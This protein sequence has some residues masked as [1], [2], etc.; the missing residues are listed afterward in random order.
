MKIGIKGDLGV[1]E[2]M[3]LLVLILR[4]RSVHKCA[5]STAEGSYSQFMVAGSE[6]LQRKSP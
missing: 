2:E 5:Q 4:A 1:A 3:A 6:G